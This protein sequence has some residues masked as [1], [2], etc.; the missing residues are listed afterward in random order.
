MLPRFFFYMLKS[1]LLLIFLFTDL[2][3]VR[4]TGTSLNLKLLAESVTR[5][6]S[7][8]NT[9]V[10]KKGV[11]E[12]GPAPIVIAMQRGSRQKR[13]VLRIHALQHTHQ[14]DLIL[15]NNRLAPHLVLLACRI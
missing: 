1:K 12:K 11:E 15:I 6:S 5:S 7:V 14:N 2:R 10:T 4:E 13:P 3:T 9:F 8:R